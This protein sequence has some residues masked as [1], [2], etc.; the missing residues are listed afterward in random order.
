[1]LMSNSPRLHETVKIGRVDQANQ[2]CCWAAH[3]HLFQIND[4]LIGIVI[5]FPRGPRISRNQGYLE[6]SC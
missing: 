3:V 5:F 4:L 2:Y 1:M 6:T